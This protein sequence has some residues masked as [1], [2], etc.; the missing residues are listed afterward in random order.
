MRF[1]TTDSIVAYVAAHP[2]S[3]GFIGSAWNHMLESKN[4]ST[5]KV[6]PLIPADSSSRGLIEPVLL[7]M[8]YIAEG[9][10]PLVT[11]VN[12]YSFEVPNTLPRGLLAYASNAHGQ[13]V[14]KNFDVLPATQPIRLVP[15]K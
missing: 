11:K 13:T 2:K 6:L 7:H 14:F 10:Y 5:V 4:D 1:S 3:I 12:G 15:S 9:L 8:G